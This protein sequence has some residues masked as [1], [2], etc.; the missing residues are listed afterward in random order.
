MRGGLSPKALPTAILR[1]I[2]EMCAT[3]PDESRQEVGGKPLSPYPLI[4]R[5]ALGF[6]LLAALL[7]AASQ[8]LAQ[9]APEAWPALPEGTRVVLLATGGDQGFL[10]PKGCN[11]QWGGALYRRPFDQWLAEKEPEV[12]RIWLSTGNLAPGHD[13]PGTVPQR[14][15]VDQFGQVGYQGVGLGSADLSGTDILALSQAALPVPILSLNLVVHETQKPVF[16]PARL[17]ET[18]AGRVWVVAV[19]DHVPEWIAGSP[20]IGTLVTIPP[21]PVLKRFIEKEKKPGDLLILLSSVHYQILRTVLESTLGIDLVLASAG[22][23]GTAE[24]EIFG[25]SPVLWLG[26]EGRLL[27]RVA[28]G[29]EGKI[30]EARSVRVRGQFPINPSTG[31]PQTPSVSPAAPSA[32]PDP[33][34]RQ[35]N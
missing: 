29:A 14:A 11:G 31:K 12:S 3:R 8:T 17:F 35:P 32:E 23:Y 28:L 6:C 26:T 21:Q 27:G 5:T 30:L 33:G 15:L 18:A 22:S 34:T 16:P 2:E 7:G 4:M 25:T 24:P 10:L 9:D 13:A 20:E 1:Q 19:T